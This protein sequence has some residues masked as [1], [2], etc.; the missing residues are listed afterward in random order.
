MED[1]EFSDEFC[2]F[3][4][5][6]IPAVDAAELLLVFHRKPDAAFSAQEAVAKLGPGIARS[7]A[8]RYLEVFASR[9]LLERVEGKFRYRPE[10]EAATHVET[11]SQAYLQRPVTLIRVIYALRDSRI[12]TFADAFKLRKG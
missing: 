6:A 11:L 3:I 4:Q 1:V 8:D 7:D 12:Q 10:N 5:V 2:R 9:G